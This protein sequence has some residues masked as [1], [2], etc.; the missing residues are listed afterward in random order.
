MTLNPNGCVASV[1]MPRGYIGTNNEI[2][3]SENDGLKFYDIFPAFQHLLPGD[4]KASSD[5][6]TEAWIE[7]WSEDSIKAVEGTYRVVIS[8]C[9]IQEDDQEEME[10]ADTSALVIDKI[11]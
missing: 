7:H 8:Q 3:L 10:W 1:E 6:S 4:A 9:W 5:Q 11:A 2:Y